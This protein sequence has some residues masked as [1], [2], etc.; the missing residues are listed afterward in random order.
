VSQSQVDG[1][2]E[3]LDA[4]QIATVA[5]AGPRFVAYALATAYCETSRTMQPIA[6]YGNGRGRRYGV[7]AGPCG[8]IYYGRGLVQLTWWSST[9][10]S[11][12][13]RGRHQVKV[14]GAAGRR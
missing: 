14:I 1:V 9:R 12:G 5:L 4:W 2:N 11:E 13:E 6:E 10:P 8:Q 7:A 3:M